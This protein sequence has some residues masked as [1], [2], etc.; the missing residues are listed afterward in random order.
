MHSCLIPRVPLKITPKGLTQI[1]FFLNEILL[2]STFKFFVSWNKFFRIAQIFLKFENVK[3]TWEVQTSN[4]YFE[5]QLKKCSAFWMANLI[6]G[7]PFGKLSNWIINTL[8]GT[9]LRW[10]TRCHV[11]M[12]SCCTFGRFARRHVDHTVTWL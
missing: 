4:N 9:L 3:H 6:F 7:S 12:R 8:F 11:K 10:L 2:T 5:K 1:R